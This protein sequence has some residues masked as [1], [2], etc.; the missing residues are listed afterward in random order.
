MLDPRFIGLGGGAGLG[1]GVGLERE[2]LAGEGLV[3]LNDLGR[4]LEL[5]CTFQVRPSKVVFDWSF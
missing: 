1:A 4:V 2:D 3:E 5:E